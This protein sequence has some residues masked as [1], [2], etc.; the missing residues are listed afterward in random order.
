[1]ARNGKNKS[2]KKKLLMVARLQED[3]GQLC[4][5]I[6]TSTSVGLASGDELHEC[7]Y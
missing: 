5:C 4:I 7:A 3:G 1:M 6:Y 2:K